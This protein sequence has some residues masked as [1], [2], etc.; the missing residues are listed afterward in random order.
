MSL[1]WK[2]QLPTPA[3]GI[4]PHKGITAPGCDQQLLCRVLFEEVA[5]KTDVAHKLM[6]SLFTSAPKAAGPEQ[7]LAQKSQP[8]VLMRSI[9]AQ[10]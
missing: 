7:C 5:L 9:Q 8:G 6:L 1:W 3:F 10:P 4:C 2:W